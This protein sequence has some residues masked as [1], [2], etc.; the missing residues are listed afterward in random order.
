MRRNDTGFLFGIGDGK[1]ACPVCGSSET[2]TEIM[3]PDFI[4]HASLKC[5]ACGHQRWLPKPTGRKQAAP[6]RHS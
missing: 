6:G 3:E 4:H 5:H 1:N 2:T